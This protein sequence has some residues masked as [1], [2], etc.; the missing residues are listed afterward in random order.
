MMTMLHP[1]KME[2]KT[3]SINHHY[4]NRK[5]WSKSWPEFCQKI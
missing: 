1:T 5:N 2:V 4:Q 3:K